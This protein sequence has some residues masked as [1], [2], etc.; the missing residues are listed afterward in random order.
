MAILTIEKAKAASH[1]DRYGTGR[2][3]LYESHEALRSIVLQLMI[4]IM[5]EWGTFERLVNEEPELY[6]QIH[7][8]MND[9]ARL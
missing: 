1:D 8:L 3:A 9:E 4:C 6:A 2:G 5:H 7:P